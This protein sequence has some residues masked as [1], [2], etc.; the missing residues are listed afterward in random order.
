MSDRLV[1]SGVAD[2]DD[3]VI[4][5]LETA[6]AL[7][8]RAE[9]AEAAR[10]LQRAAGAARK[11]GRPERAG[12]LSRL[13][14]RLNGTP[15]AVTPDDKFEPLEERQHVLGDDDEFADKTIV[16]ELP[17]PSAEATSAPASTSGPATERN[18]A[19][20][21]EASSAG[22]PRP[23]TRT[24]PAT[25]ASASTKPA[26]PSAGRSAPSTSPRLDKPTPVA[27]LTARKEP[28]IHATIRVAVRK[29]LGGS[30]EV[31]PLEPG[32]ELVSGEE[33]ALLVPIK[34]G[35]RWS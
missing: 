22:P 32:D 16:D 6:R 29:S 7:E 34:A 23:A 2:D 24:K 26:A 4:V 35:T 31:R 3:D 21:S 12:E 25:P 14:A 33:E 27:P 1:P 11:Q 18:V 13:A 20:P 5:A 17:R 28:S 15:L 9:N 10:W 8:D 19:P 30:F